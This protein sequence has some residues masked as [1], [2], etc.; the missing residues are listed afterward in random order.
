MDYLYLRI[1]IDH[2]QQ[3]LYGL[4]DTRE[5]IGW[6]VVYQHPHGVLGV[7]ALREFADPF[8]HIKG[9]HSIVVEEPPLHAGS[10]VVFKA[11]GWGGSAGALGPAEVHVASFFRLCHK[12]AHL[13]L[14]VLV[15]HGQIC[16]DPECFC[17]LSTVV[18]LRCAYLGASKRS[19]K[20]EELHYDG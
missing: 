16:H 14:E 20:A 3:P 8:Q 6:L 10:E 13:D 17:S 1:S 19:W 5:G 4:L 15:R 9:A 7:G 12:G 18:S 11:L 2:V